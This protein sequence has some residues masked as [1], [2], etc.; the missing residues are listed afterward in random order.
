MPGWVCSSRMSWAVKQ[1][2]FLAD[3]SLFWTSP[4]P[5][6]KP[7]PILDLASLFYPL[8]ILFW[9][10]IPILLFF[11]CELWLQH[12]PF[13]KILATGCML[14][15]IATYLWISLI[16]DQSCCVACKASLLWSQLANLQ[17]LSLVFWN[18]KYLAQ[19]YLQ[20][21]GLLSSHQTITI[22][23]RILSLKLRSVFWRSPTC[24]FFLDVFSQYDRDKQQLGPQKISELKGVSHCQPDYV[25]FHSSVV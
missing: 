7:S 16:M 11:Q 15:V 20:T 17:S 8:P 2:D 12:L 25:I 24:E 3:T 9:L 6:C 10:C 21:W 5:S 14:V 23:W 22:L 13:F 18:L 4:S 1:G 19:S